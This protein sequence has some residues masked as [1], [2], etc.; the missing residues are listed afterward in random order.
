MRSANTAE[1]DWMPSGGD[2]GLGGRESRISGFGD[3]GNQIDGARGGGILG[4]HDRKLDF[5][6]KQAVETEWVP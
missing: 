4:Q 6:R 1:D 3:L 5:A 2:R